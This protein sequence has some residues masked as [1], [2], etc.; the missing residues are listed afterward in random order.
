MKGII[1]TLWRL[2]LAW[3]WPHSPTRRHHVTPRH[4]EHAFRRALLRE[5]LSE[6]KRDSAFAAPPTRRHS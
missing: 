5:A 1:V 4:N 2:V 6:L 3:L